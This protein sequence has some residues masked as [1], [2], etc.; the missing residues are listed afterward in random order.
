MQKLNWHIGNVEIANPIVIAPMAG[1][2]NCAFRSICKE[3]D[4]GLIY[5]EMISD[6]ALF[7]HNVKTVDMCKVEQ[8]EH[9]ITLQLF[10]SDIESMVLAAQY[11]DKHSDCDI[12]DINMGCP[13]QKVV[14]NNCGSALMKDEVHSIKLVEA[15]VKAVKKPVSVKMRI[16]WDDD[17]INC[18]SLARQLEKVG[19]SCLAIH[20]RTRKQMYE[21]KARWEIIGEV[22]RAVSIPVIGNGD[23][24]SVQD[25]LAMKEI[26]NCDAFMIGRAIVGNPFLI[27]EA[28]Y[29]L[30]NEGKQ[31]II[32]DGEKLELLLTHTKRLIKLKN[33][34]VAC[35]EMRG[36]AGSYVKGFRH[37]NQLKNAFA[38]ISTY[39]ELETI[40]SEY[41]HTEELA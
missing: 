39:K 26:T 23:I 38:K 22:K 21:G 15:I 32:N 2:S 28:L 14:K 37:A 8:G 5:S 7:Y 10:G 18:V 34:V 30:E 6:K 36:L 12:I 41:L 33:E 19:V 1:V 31:L 40:I 20:A 3:F 9:P 35:K 27:K 29:A 25:L 24:S 13:V 16:G 11:L 17:H 4:A